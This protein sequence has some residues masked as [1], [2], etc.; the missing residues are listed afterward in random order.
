M[1]KEFFK[2]FLINYWERS[3]DFS[4]FCFVEK[5]FFYFFIFLQKIYCFF[6]VVVLF[7]KKR[8]VKKNKY[9]F[10]VVSIGNISVGG[11]GKSVLV[12]YLVKK[13]CLNKKCAIVLRGYKSLAEKTGKS[14]V[15]VE[16]KLKDT[17]AVFFG[18]EAV[19]L[20]RNLSVPVVVGN[21]RVRSCDLLKDEIDL[22]FLDDAYQ[23]LSIK[24]DFEILLL[25]ARHP[26]ENGYCLPAGKLREKDC[27]RAD[28]IILTHTESLDFDNIE[29]IKKQLYF[30]TQ[31]KNIYCAMHNFD[32]LFFNDKDFIDLKLLK[33]NKNMAFAGIGDFD[34][35][36]NFLLDIGLRNCEFKSYSDHYD[37]GK[38]DIDE[39]FL[40]AKRLGINSII[41]TQKDWVKISKYLL[42]KNDIPVYVVRIKFKFLFN[43]EKKFLD[44][45]KINIQ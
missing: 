18:D 13:C 24:K 22:V 8:F 16:K 30:K 9:N 35:F 15:V 5:L 1:N 42:H 14:F 11:T 21:N 33:K 32:G 29:K 23:N 17:Q 4:Q 27:S 20:S 41:T 26:F 36:K 43:D 6:F 19:M 2:N 25:D 45:L 44:Q 3:Y 12:Q 10:K 31:H 39:L 37:Y 40:N 38:D 7:Y 34:S 28:C